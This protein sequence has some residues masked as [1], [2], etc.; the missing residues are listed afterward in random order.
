MWAILLVAIVLA[1]MLLKYRET[2]VVKYG[3]PFDNEDIIS[4]DYDAKGTRLFAIWPDTCPLDR[5]DYDAGLCYEQCEEGY[6]GVGPVCWASTTSR[7]IGKLPRPKSC[8]EM[9]LSAKYRDD[10]LSCWKDLSCEST[11]T[12]DKR[13]LFGNCYAWDLKISCEGPDLK[14]KEMSCPGPQWA[15]NDESYTDMVDGLCYKKCPEDASSFIPGMPYLC[16]AG[17]RG[18]SYGRGVGTVPPIIRFGA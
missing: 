17:T 1:F 4:F 15:G 8:S 6:H 16:T 3:N 13:D 10:P 18:L 14:W 9:G 2:F 7:G 12:S 5:P 11:C